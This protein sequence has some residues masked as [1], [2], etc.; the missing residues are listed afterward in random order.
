MGIRG[1]EWVARELEGYEAC[2]ISTDRQL[3][4]S[5]GFERFMAVP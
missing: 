4:M 1:V 2:A 3:V 5:A